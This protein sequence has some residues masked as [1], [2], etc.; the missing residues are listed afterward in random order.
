[1]A[2]VTLSSGRAVGGPLLGRVAA[3]AGEL[4]FRVVA[5]A[6]AAVGAWAAAVAAAWEDNFLLPDECRRARKAPPA[7][8][9]FYR[10]A[11]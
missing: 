11:R 5:A 6:W 8:S 2:A 3:A 7:L 9:Y 10:I 4:S 1:V